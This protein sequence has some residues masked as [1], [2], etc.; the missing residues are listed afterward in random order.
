MGDLNLEK[1]NFFREEVFLN[2]V[3]RSIWGAVITVTKKRCYFRSNQIYQEL[4]WKVKVKVSVQ[5]LRKGANK[6]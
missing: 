4:F 1:V 3:G 5:F 2:M 6:C